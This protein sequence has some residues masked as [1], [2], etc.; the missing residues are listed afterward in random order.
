[1]IKSKGLRALD[2]SELDAVNGGV[3][4]GTPMKKVYLKDLTTE[5]LSY[6]LMGQCPY[7]HSTMQAFDLHFGCAGAACMTVF[8]E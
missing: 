1:M 7:C 8:I 6:Y 2:D 3:G 4:E 5:Q